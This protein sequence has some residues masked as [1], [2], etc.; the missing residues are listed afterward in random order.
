M[1]GVG[2]R[3]RRV[4]AHDVH[5]VNL[6]GVHGVHDLHHREPGLR[7]ELAA[8]K[9]F[10][11]GPCVIVVH[12]LIVGKHHGDQPRVRRA[13]HVVLAAQRMQSAPRTA[14]L[15]GD[16]AKRDQAAGVIGPVDVL[17][18]AHAPQDHRA[19][20]SREHS[21]DLAD[22]LRR[23]SAEGLHRLRR[24][25]FDVLRELFVSDRAPSDEVLVDQPLG[26]DRVHH[27]VQKRDVGIG[28][29]LEIVGG[30]ARELESARICQDELHTL[31]ARVLDPRG[32]DRVVDRGAGADQK[33][34]LGLHDVRHLVRHRSR[35]DAFHQRRDTGGMAQARAVI[36]VVAAKPGAHQLLEQVSFLVAPLG[37]AESGQRARA[38]RVA[39]FRQRAACEIERLL[40]RGLAKHRGDVVRVHDEV[41]IL[42]RA[43]LAN[44]G[45]REA[46][47]VMH[48]IESVAPLHA[49]APVIGGPVASLHVQDG[50]VL[51]VIR[52]QAA[53]A[54]VWTHRVHRLVRHRQPDAAGRHQRPRGTGLHALAAGDAGALAHGITGI[55]HD[56]GA[57]AAEGE[58][59]DVVDL[60][61]AARAHAARTLNAGIQIHRDGRVRQVRV[62][63][64]ARREARLAQLH[65]PRPLVQLGIE[66]VGPLRHVRKEKLEDHFLRRACALVFGVHFHARLGKP[67]TR[68]RQ[69]SLALDLDHA[70]AAVSVGAVTLF[71]A[72]VGDL[73]PV[74]FGDLQDRLVAAPGQRSAIQGEFDQRRLEF[75]FQHGS[76]SLPRL[77]IRVRAVA[78]RGAAAA[79]P[80]RSP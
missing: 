14:H 58:A 25:P 59:D 80:V 67:A 37:R 49:Q 79:V 44:Q 70:R 51:D 9:V 17:G 15:P 40:P 74:A 22:G 55:E 63:R 45:P 73:D 8:P 52:E 56:L 11:S 42:R 27:R 41:P 78:R 36:D 21:G 31:L 18:N 46:L 2:I 65:L 39:D 28:L 57:R 5:A 38:T 13:L 43:G 23:N 30:V 62:R 47:S 26:H 35:A 64:Q 10:E 24:E 72:K 7:I 50:V 12:T 19:P 54:A 6:S 20:G 1:H 48:V 32:G 69:N 16:Q 75:V 76:H 68:R 34:D 29:D 4:L 3:H 33:H 66:R 61:L 77:S 60:L 71:V 53:H